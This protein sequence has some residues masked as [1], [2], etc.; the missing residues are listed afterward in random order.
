[1]LSNQI[2]NILNRQ[3]NEEI[4][5]SNLYLSLS[6]FLE[7]MNYK[8]MAAWMRRQS[9][10]ERKHAMKLYDFM[11]D[12]GSRT[13]TTSLPAPP[14]SWSSVLDAFSAAYRHE[15]KMSE[16]IGQMVNAA[17]EADDHAT[18]NFLQ[19]FVHKQAEEEAAFRDILGRMRI[20][21]EDSQGMYMIDRELGD[22]S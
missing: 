21:E 10:D 15:Q 18:Y 9:E 12:S 7:A 13:L 16:H 11:I 6:S 14:T 1:M 20:V 5:S 17:R 8:G 3:F 19:W 22:E 4:Y 2:Q